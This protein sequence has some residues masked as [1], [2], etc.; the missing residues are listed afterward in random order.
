M[1]KVI[2]SKLPGSYDVLDEISAEV[3]G[4]IHLGELDPLLGRHP[5]HFSL[6]APCNF[7]RLT[8]QVNQID[9]VRA[10]LD[11]IQVGA[12]MAQAMESERK[13]G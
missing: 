8:E 3:V 12:K 5:D 13:N 7:S 10:R 4:Y 9:I 2:P 1:P 11:M 6:L